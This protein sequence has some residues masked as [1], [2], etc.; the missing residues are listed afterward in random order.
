MAISDTH[1]AFESIVSDARV[2][3]A[4][5]CY[6]FNQ[7]QRESQSDTGNIESN[8]NTNISKEVHCCGT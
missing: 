8:Q 3:T 5:I 7:N 2:K 4:F 1:F 6:S